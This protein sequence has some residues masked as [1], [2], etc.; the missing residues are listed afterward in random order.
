MTPTSTRPT[1]KRAR[2]LVLASLAGLLAACSGGDDDISVSPPAPPPPPP[3]APVAL[4]CDDTMKTAYRPDSDTTVLLVKAYRAGEPLAL[5]GTTGTPPT[6]AQDLC[7]VKLRVGPGS[8]GTAGAPSTS[9]GIGIEVWLP[10]LANWNERIR[11]LG[12]GGWAGGNHLNT[13]LVAS[14][15]AAAIAGTGFV[16]GTTDT[17]HSGPGG[18]SFAMKEDGGFNTALWRDFSER[19]L[20]Q[21]AEKTRSLARAYY[22]KPQRYAYWQGCSTGGRQGYKVAQERPD[23]YDGF[24]NEAPVVNW[25]RFITQELYPQIVIRRDLVDIGQTLTTAQLGFVSSRAVSACD[26]VGGGRL[27]FILDPRQCRYDPTR[28]AAA[29]CTG[30]VGNGVTGTST[31]AQCVNA[32]QARA[33]NKIWYGQTIDGSVPD[34]QADVGSTPFLAS[35]NHLWW[36]LSRGANLGLLANTASPF[37]VATDMAALTLQ[38]PSYG[39]PSFVNATGNGVNRWRD[40]GYADMAFIFQQAINLQPFFGDINTDKADLSGLRDRGGKIIH[41]HGW[42]DQLVPAMGSINYYQR[43][44]NAMG[45]FTETQK[46]NRLY[47]VPGLGHCGGVGTISGSDSPAANTNSVPLPTNQQLFDALVAWVE[48]GTAPNRIVVRSANASVSMPI[49]PFPRKATYSGTGSITDEASY[50]CQ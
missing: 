23:L 18:G 45:G 28:D 16:V 5:S 50:T 38:D 7:L 10:T 14:T 22:L 17:G 33:V 42:G 39:T 40:L 12:G 25:S 9:P 27:G 46:F 1:S 36:G 11:N 32:V 29:L 19:G 2:L 37:G 15:Q 21:L 35:S 6:A 24:L 41:F 48:T 8:P 49:C 44:A 26:A 47:M 20:V 34:P 4:Q 13:A 3:P 31:N 43:V 30:E